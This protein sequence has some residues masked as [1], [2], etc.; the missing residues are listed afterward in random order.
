MWNIEICP[1]LLGDVAVIWD[2]DAVEVPVQ[3][4]TVAGAGG[5]VWAD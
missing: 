5:A 3:P 4:I 2:N 1:E